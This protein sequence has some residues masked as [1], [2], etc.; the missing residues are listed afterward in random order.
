MRKGDSLYAI[1]QRFGVS[2]PVLR[3]ANNL[4][5]N[6][7]RQGE[8]LLVPGGGQKSNLAAQPAN[9]GKNAGSAQASSYRTASYTPVNTGGRPIHT[10]RR[11]ENLY[12]I[13]QGYG[14]SVSSL[15]AANGMSASERFLV[16]GQKLVIPASGS[17]TSTARTARNVYIV[18]K[19]DTLY[20]LAQRNN[21]SLDELMR[22]NGLKR[23]KPIMPGQELLIP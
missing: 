6:S 8:L 15:Q 13:A 11:G 20:S 1:G 17:K 14:I 10:V 5:S 21:I 23:G 2:V 19:G 7:L 12:Q 9:N 4:K 16:S 22:V 18:Q 3:E